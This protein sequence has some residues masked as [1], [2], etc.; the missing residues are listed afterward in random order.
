MHVHRYRPLA[1]VAAAGLIAASATA[2]QAQSVEQ[3]YHGRTMTMMIPAAPGGVNDLASR[4]VAQYLGRHIPGNPT[5]TPQNLPGGAG[6]VGANRMYNSVE[7]DGSVV[8]ILDRGAPQVAILGDPNAKF[9]PTR[10][11]LLGSISSYQH[12]AYILAINA[13]SPVK[14]VEDLRKPG[15]SITLGGMN[16]GVTN[17]TFALIAK[18][19]LGL[20]IKV[21]RGYTGANPMFLAMQRGEIDGQVVGLSSLKAGQPHLWADKLVTVLIQFGRATRLKPELADVPTGRELAKTDEARALIEFAEQPFFAALPYIAPPGI[22]PDRAA[23]LQKAFMDTMK[24][25]D[26]VA[27]AHRLSL[28]LSPIDGETVRRAIQKAAAT[29]KDIIARYNRIVGR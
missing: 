7:K 9:D 16:A 14:T 10:F 1:C 27:G 12:D 28:D 11:T 5:V 24:D 26:F 20:P 23:A 17:L 19:V 21:V 25:P 22:P 4:L 18:E 6:I 13:R 3:F 8:S 15:A 29:P 2:A